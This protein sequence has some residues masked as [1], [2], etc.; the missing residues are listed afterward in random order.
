MFFSA[1]CA[2]IDTSSQEGRFV[3]WRQGSPHGGEIP[4]FFCAEKSN[5]GNRFPPSA[6]TSPLADDS[7]PTAFVAGYFSKFVA[8][9]QGGTIQKPKTVPSFYEK[10][11]SPPRELFRREFLS[12]VHFSDCSTW[13]VTAV[14]RGMFYTDFLAHC[15]ESLRRRSQAKV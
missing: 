13:R 8:G 3:S 15:Q 5:G 1:R 14:S 2:I 11:S 12:C 4:A 9:A 10:P 6:E 7:S